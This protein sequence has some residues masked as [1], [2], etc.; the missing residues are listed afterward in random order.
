[1]KIEYYSESQKEIINFLKT[2]YRKWYS[3]KE[4]GKIFDYKISKIQYDVKILVDKNTIDRK[5]F[6]LKSGKY[7][8]YRYSKNDR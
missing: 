5:T 6:P 2:N 1:M 4:I 7:Y 3:V 8:V